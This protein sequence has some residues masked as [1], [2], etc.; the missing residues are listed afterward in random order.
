[1]TKGAVWMDELFKENSGNFY[2]Y[3]RRGNE[4]HQMEV[5]VQRLR[6]GFTTRSDAQRKGEFPMSIQELNNGVVTR[7]YRQWPPSKVW[8]DGTAGGCCALAMYYLNPEF[9]KDMVDDLLQKSHEQLEIREL[10]TIAVTNGT[11]KIIQDMNERLKLSFLRRIY[12]KK[13][14]PLMLSNVNTLFGDS[15]DTG[16]FLVEICEKE[17]SIHNNVSHFV[18]LDTHAMEIYD[19]LCEQGAIVVYRNSSDHCIFLEMLERNPK[20]CWIL[21][22]WRLENKAH[23]SGMKRDSCNGPTMDLPEVEN[24]KKRSR[25]IRKMNNQNN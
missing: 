4:L 25:K 2:F 23:S 21:N 18:S 10:T 5:K 17:R 1:M 6:G 19:P 24:K 3:D 22:I 7:A 15:K 8:L 11:Y 12:P 9:T 13:A 14:Q 20:D 16:K